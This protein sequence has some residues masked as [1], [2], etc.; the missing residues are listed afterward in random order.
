MRRLLVRIPYEGVR[1]FNEIER[2]TLIN[3]KSSHRTGMFFPVDYFPSSMAGPS[4]KNSR[5]I[6]GRRGISSRFFRRF[7]FV[8]PHGPGRG[9]EW[10]ACGRVYFQDSRLSRSRPTGLALLNAAHF[11]RPPT[12]GFSMGRTHQSIVQRPVRGPVNPPTTH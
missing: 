11:R 6:G 7:D 5:P 4:K 10:S 2:K 8:S 9:Q 3:R 1:R 12:V